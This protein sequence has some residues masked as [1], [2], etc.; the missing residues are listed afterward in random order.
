[1]GCSAINSASLLLYRGAERRPHGTTS[2]PCTGRDAYATY[3]NIIT[4][5]DKNDQYLFAP[6]RI[7]NAQKRENDGVGPGRDPEGDVILYGGLG[8]A[9]IRQEP[10]LLEVQIE[11]PVQDSQCWVELGVQPAIAAGSVGGVFAPDT[12]DNIDPCE[13]QGADDGPGELSRPF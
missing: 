8:A 5:L 9:E 4:E 2:L 1:M 7:Q 11:E 10:E 13:A 6:E 12:E 3:K